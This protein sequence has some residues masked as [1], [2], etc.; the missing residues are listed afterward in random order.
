MVNM[1]ILIETERLYLK[2]LNSNHAEEVLTFYTKNK[3]NFEKWEPAR[4]PSFYTIDFHI[5]N[6]NLEFNQILQS[7]FLRYW[8]F[9]KTDPTTIIGSVCFQH[10]I[11]GAFQSCSIG[12]KM[13]A[14]H[15]RKGYAT[16]A[17]QRTIDFV[18]TDLSIH[19]IEAYIALNNIASIHFIEKLGFQW[20]GIAKS[21]IKLNIH[22][23]DHL[24]YAL[25]N[26]RDY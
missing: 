21:S 1:Q 17:V 6:L 20:E 16:E 5:A 19:R 18:F 12:Y 4:V 23:E 25:I 7:N 26:P 10:F 14:S 15:I 11:R 13:D 8:I 9:R 2:V 3:E 24:Q 22:W